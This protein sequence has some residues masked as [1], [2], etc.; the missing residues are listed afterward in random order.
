M[1]NIGYLNEKQN[2]FCQTLFVTSYNAD[3][4]GKG[5]S[6]RKTD[7]D[8]FISQN[9]KYINVLIFIASIQ[10]VRKYF[11]PNHSDIFLWAF[12]K[13]KINLNSITYCM[14]SFDGFKQKS[15]IK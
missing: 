13:C 9:C 1:A 11:C 10:K 2:K 3:A 14:F 8:F 4:H 5:Y 6:Q 7:T 12:Y 15:V